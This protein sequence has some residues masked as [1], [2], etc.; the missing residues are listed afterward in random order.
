M[1][2]FTFLISFFV[3]TIITS[4]SK[5]AETI[6]PVKSDST[7][8]L[9]TVNGG[10]GLY[11]VGYETF[12]HVG[13]DSVANAASVHNVAKVWK[14]GIAVNL[15]DDTYDA[16]ANAVYANQS[17][18][19]VVG[20]ESNSAGFKVAT[21]WKNG[22]ATRLGDGKNDSYAKSIFVDGSDVYVVGNIEIN[23]LSSGMFWKNGV[24][25]ALTNCANANSVTVSNGEVYVCGSDVNLIPTLWKNGVGTNLPNPGGHGAANSISISTIGE[26]FIGG[27]FQ[28]NGTIPGYWDNEKFNFLGYVSGVGY[29]PGEVKSVL[30]NGIDV[31]LLGFNDYGDVLWL[32][33]VFTQVIYRKDPAPNATSNVSDY[34]TSIAIG[35]ISP[36]LGGWRKTYLIGDYIHLHDVTLPLLWTAGQ[37]S[38]L[39]NGDA[40]AI[41]KLFNKTGGKVNSVFVVK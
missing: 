41:K 27:S 25:S 21:L 3:L 2:T 8:T 6:T 12:Y 14:N 23:S 18:V 5:N 33:N 11:A 16:S 38:I 19:Y 39:D 4:C 17:D 7:V 36:V 35:N 31:Y 9:G 30:V 37:V 34:V 28:N 22:V 29:L 40:P 13:S 10:V 20:F 24:S 32:N 1:R 26:R 15:S